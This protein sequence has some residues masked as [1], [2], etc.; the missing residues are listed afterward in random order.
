MAFDFKKEYREYY[1]PKDRPELI[2]VPEARFI[3]VDGQG[4]PNE[5]DGAYQRAVGA[6]YAVAYTVKMSKKGE[7]ALE[8]YFDFVV[9]PLEGFWRQAGTM[10]VDYAR[11]ADF[12]WTACLR[13][14]DFVTGEVLQWAADEASRKKGTDCSDVRLMTLREGL[15]VQM[16]HVGPYDDEPASVQRMDA[17]VA[18][19]GYVNDL[20]NERLHHEIYL[21]DPRKV[22]PERMKTVIRH[23]IRKK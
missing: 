22:P 21:S 3:A 12:L 17:F 7:Q 15:C 16:M 11:K 9:P 20:S 5:P 8:G 23:P 14:P 6:L 4:D 2:D 13:V 1:L 19:Q 10:G 18:G